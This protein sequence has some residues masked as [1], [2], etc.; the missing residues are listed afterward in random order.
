MKYLINRK[1]PE[2]SESQN[3][4]GF[5]LV[6]L[7]VVLVILAILAAILTPALLGY[8]DRARSEK[9]YATAQTIR[10]AA[11]AQIDQAYGDGYKTA[12]TGAHTAITRIADFDGVMADTTE[13]YGAGVFK[14]AGVDTSKVTAF[15]FEYV[16]GLIKT[17]QVTI[18]GHVYYLLENG[19][20][21]T[22]DSGTGSTGG[23]TG[24][25]TGGGESGGQ[26]GGGNS[27]NNGQH[28]GQGNGN[29][30]HG[31]ENAGPGNNSGNGN[32]D[33]QG[34]GNGQNNGQHNGQNNGQHNGHNNN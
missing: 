9:D 26:T 15:S 31:N 24:G 33:P 19:T 23:Q 5:T 16:S 17:G 34:T 12:A 32:T 28:N 2:W 20:W 14:L 21:T 7:I 13:D 6:E 10:V 30:H 3:S 29:A 25:Q 1:R 22:T 8:I 11:Q 4:K 18:D 27:Q